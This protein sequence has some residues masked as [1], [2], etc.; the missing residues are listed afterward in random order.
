MH[1]TKYAVQQLLILKKSRKQCVSRNN[2][3]STFEEIISGVPQR[4]IV[5]PTFFN[6]LIN[7]FFYFILVAMAH[8]FA[9]DNTLKQ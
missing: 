3:K 9:D 6:V 2:I 5:G 1:L 7:D 4:S 8:N